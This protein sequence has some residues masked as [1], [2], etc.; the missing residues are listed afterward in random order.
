MN[1]TKKDRERMKAEPGPTGK[2]MPTIHDERKQVEFPG[3]AIKEFVSISLSPKPKTRIVVEHVLNAEHPLRRYAVPPQ[4][5]TAQKT[6]PVFA[7]RWGR[8]IWTWRPA[9]NLLK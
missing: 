8:I 3:L 7:T 5:R 9:R 2:Q 6:T 4:N 1:Y